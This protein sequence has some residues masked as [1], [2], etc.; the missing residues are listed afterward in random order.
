LEIVDLHGNN[1]TSLP[2]NMGYLTRLRILNI[3]ENS[4]ESLPLDILATLPVTE[5]LARKNQLSGALFPDSV[6]SFSSL[7][8]MDVSSNQLA[9]LASPGHTITMPALHQ[10]CISMNRLQGLP[11]ISSWTSL[12]TLVAEENS[13]SAIPTGFFGLQKLRSVDFS[14]NDIRVVPPE[15]GRMEN[16][17]M[18]RLSGNPLRDKRFA[19][20]STDEMKDILASRLEPPVVH[21]V[22]VDGGLDSAFGGTIQGK[23]ENETGMSASRDGEDSDDDHFA[24]PPTSVNQTPERARANSSATQIWPVKAGGILDRSGTESSAL[25]PVI[26]SRIAGAND[27]RE[28]RLSKNLFTALPDSLCFFSHSLTILSLSHNKLDGGTYAG[29]LSGNGELDLPALKELNLSWNHITSLT[30]LTTSLRAPQLQKLDV[31][32]NRLSALPAGTQLRDSFPNLTILFVSDNHLIDLHPDS[33]RGMKVVD[34]NNNDIE[35]LNPR[36]G[37]LGGK[38]GLEQLSVRGNR[39]RVPRF[40]V[41]DRGTEA[42]LRWLRGRVPL[43]EMPKNRGSSGDDDDGDLG[44]ALVD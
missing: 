37:L 8:V 43:D 34:A 39:F 44:S 26:C 14:S 18:L 42:T 19:T 40:S 6:K 31:S 11:D 41:L 30:P 32:F 25:H 22:P 16:L 1:I 12:I 13:I 28:V 3:S 20:I 9:E 29:S 24:T 27:V 4:F 21:D 23:V 33:I 17:A 10:L 7:Q 38:G 36:L 15:I 35:R 5:L 2:S